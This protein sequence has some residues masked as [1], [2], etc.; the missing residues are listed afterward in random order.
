MPPK[1]AFPHVTLIGSHRDTHIEILY[2][3]QAPRVTMAA[4]CVVH[5]NCAL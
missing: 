5:K 2:V 4:P 3:L 1:G